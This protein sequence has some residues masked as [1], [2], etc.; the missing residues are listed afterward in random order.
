[1]RIPF[2]ELHQTLLR[3]LL[4]LGFNTDRASRCARLFAETTCDG[5]Y[6]HGVNRFLRFVAMIQNGCINV[7]GEPER[8]SHFAALERWDG[9]KGPGNL[10]ACV[11]M[12]RATGLSREY[13]I[14]CVSLRNTNHWMRGESYGWRAAEMGSIAFCWT[15]TL[16]NLPPW[17]GTEPCIGNNP[18]VI[19]IPRKR[20]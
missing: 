5:V 16:P 19:A 18:V 15:N 4:K 2:D 6:T 11:A 7:H 20:G 14:G 17:G 3:V 13:G 1:M 9:R 8:I 10:N 12:D